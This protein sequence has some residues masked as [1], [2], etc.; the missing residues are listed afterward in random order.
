MRIYQSKI[1]DYGE[2]NISPR[3]LDK[4]FVGSHDMGIAILRSWNRIQFTTDITL[5]TYFNTP[6]W[7][8]SLIRRAD[9]PILY[10]SIV[11]SNFCSISDFWSESE[12]RPL[13]FQECLD[14][15]GPIQN[16][17]VLMYNSILA[18]IPKYWKQIIRSWENFT[19]EEGK[20]ESL[21]VKV[22][23]SKYLYWKCIDMNIQYVDSS[24]YLWAKDLSIDTE[25]LGENWP[26]LLEGIRSIT[27][28]A[29]LRYFAI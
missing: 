7:C 2:C 29:K 22:H 13:S 11:N 24:C 28:S 3:D 1:R 19:Y 20:V 6:I 5:A 21:A 25:I 4:Y 8:N 16:L 12:N 18:A 23:P 15:H 10:Y 14:R 9:Q 17:D 27:K 26:T